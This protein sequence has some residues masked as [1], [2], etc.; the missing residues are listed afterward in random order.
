[1]GS[2]KLDSLTSP[3]E[4][5]SCAATCLLI[6]LEPGTSASSRFAGF[7]ANA[8]VLLAES[9]PRSLQLPL[10]IGV[11]SNIEFFGGSWIFKL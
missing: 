3:K 9:W 10:F 11:L 7:C 6:G 5:V 1:M 8:C 4:T 2:G